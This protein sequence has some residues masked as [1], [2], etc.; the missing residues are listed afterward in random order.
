M[1]RALIIFG[2]LAL[3]VLLP[4]SMRRETATVSP[5]KAEDHLVIITPHNQ[6]IREEFGEAFAAWWKTKTGRTIYV[7]WRNPGGTSEIRMVLD[8]GFR[9]A[10]E[11]QREGLGIDVFFGGGEPDFASQAKQQRL[12]PLAVFTR[13]PDWFGDQAAIPSSFTGETY[14]PADHVWVGCCV[15]RFGVAYNPDVLKRLGAKIPQR[16]DDLAD[17]KLLGAVALADPTKSGSVAR[18]FELVVQDQMQR[19][20]SNAGPDLEKAK[21]EGWDNA[22]RLI[23]QMGAN[24]RYFTDSASKVPHDIGQGDSAAGMCIDFYG[25]SY[26]EELLRPDGTS[27]VE[28]VSPIGG[29]TLSADPI[30]VLKGAPHAEIAQ[31]FVEFVLSPEGQTLWSGKPGSPG[32]PRT[33]ALYRSP[34][35]RDIY[36]PVILA[37][38]TNP[39]S[40]PYTAGDA[41]TYDKELTGKAFNTLRNLVKIACIDSH[42]EMKQAWQ[43]M[44]TA[45]FPEEAMTAFCNVSAISYEKMGKGN[46]QLDNKDNPLAAAAKAAELGEWFRANYRI[47]GQLAKQAPQTSPTR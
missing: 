28:W 4:I 18:A 33:H 13:H 10:E 46:P 37:N 29:A 1:K 12:V 31:A 39:G 23:L 40:N 6:S 21:A 27:R 41:I 19:A 34:I 45:G 17:P 44:K 26:H 15:S 11:S 5:E 14:F 36:T 20:L 43:A 24:A 2:L 38:S 3:I 35:R 30:A 9:A 32:G 22:M 47:A 25:R 16:W 7:D 42:E 8:A